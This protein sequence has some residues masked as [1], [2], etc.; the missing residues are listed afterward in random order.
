MDRLLF[1]NV[2]WM[3]KYQGLKRDT[4]SGGGRHISVHGFGHEILNFQ[5]YRGRMYGFAQVPH[6][7]MKIEKLGAP[8]GAQSVDGVVVA[9]VAKS[10]IVGWYRDATVFRRVQ[11]P[12]KHSARVYQGKLIGYNVTGD[13]GKCKILSPDAR[14]FAIPRSKNRKHAMGRY[15]WYAEGPQNQSFRERVLAYIAADGVLPLTHK[16]DL[17]IA[18][19]GRQ[20]DIYKRHRIE[21]SAIDMTAKTFRGPGL[22]S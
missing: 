9:W 5:P 10:R 6:S 14:L 22:R 3:S 19:R 1:L 17:R 18:G 20:S 4:I 12:P 7:S 15:L 16:S 13:A 21:E 2:G 8:K 11:P